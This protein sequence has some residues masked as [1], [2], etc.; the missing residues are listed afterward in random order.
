MLAALYLYPFLATVRCERD[1]D[2]APIPSRPQ[3]EEDQQLKGELEMLVERLKVSCTHTVYCYAPPCRWPFPAEQG[4]VIASLTPLRPACAYP[5]LKR[6]TYNPQEPDTTLYHPALESL[7]TLIRTSTASMTSVPKP[8]KFLHPL[9]PDL[10][11]LYEKWP[12][13]SSANGSSK[14][15]FAEILSVL[16]MTYSDSGKRETLSYR[17][18]GGSEEDPGLWGH[19][20][21]RHLAA[22]IEEEYAVRTD[23]PEEATFTAEEL[24]ALALRL[25]PFLLSHNGEA[26]AVDLLLEIESISSIIPFVDENTYT[27]VCL[28]MT[29]C[30]NLLQPPDDRDFLKC[31]REIYRKFEKY[32]QAIVCSL[33]LGDQEL[34]KEDFSAPKNPCVFQ[35]SHE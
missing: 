11:E 17:L 5:T 15:L 7:R 24:H 25:V 21:V 30:V 9:Y 31:A 19:E 10:Q 2:D 20:Y 22:E 6:H 13:T 18:K 26:D 16:A 1:C 3:S 14:S 23:K 35:L 27:R 33:R 8:L 4:P 12:S 32:S 28:Y 34:I 29:T